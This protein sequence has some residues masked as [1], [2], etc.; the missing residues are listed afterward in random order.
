MDI[1]DSLS[2]EGDLVVDEVLDVVEVDLTGNTLTKGLDQNAHILLGE[3]GTELLE[4]LNGLPVL[5]KRC[6][7]LIELEDAHH[8]RL[9]LSKALGI[10]SLELFGILNNLL[11]DLVRIVNEH[12]EVGILILDLSGEILN[13]SFPLDLPLRNLGREELEFV[14]IGL[15]FVGGL[16]LLDLKIL[17]GHLS[18]PDIGAE[19]SELLLD[20]IH[21]LVL[22]GEGVDVVGD[23]VGVLLN[24]SGHGLSV[25][26]KLGELRIAD[27]VT[28]AGIGAAE[29]I[30]GG[31][32][33]ES[34][35]LLDLVMMRKIVLWMI[36]FFTKLPVDDVGEGFSHEPMTLGCRGCLSNMGE[37]N[38]AEKND[39]FE[40]HFS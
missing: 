7:I 26:L 18:C 34:V 11:E 8:E 6:L 24:H 37:G 17:G 4:S 1:L 33:R 36:Y 27:S 35:F 15:E 38:D 10:L 2:L 3:L 39:C 23:G 5:L 40:L 21:L 13:P 16:G 25:V 28:E 29:V 31:Q 9:N 12:I 22:T 30:L 19:S 20:V 14:L 32:K